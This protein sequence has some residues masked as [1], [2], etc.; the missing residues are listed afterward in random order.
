MYR[1]CLDQASLEWSPFHQLR[2]FLYL[3]Y[4]PRLK[5]CFDFL[6][7]QIAIRV[8][9]RASV[10]IPTNAF[11]ATLGTSCSRVPAKQVA[12]APSSLVTSERVKVSPSTI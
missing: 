5:S 10:L 2:L 1:S 11:P 4:N 7:G 6:L 8:V 12:L 3:I 9:A